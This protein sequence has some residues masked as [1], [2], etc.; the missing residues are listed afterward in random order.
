MHAAARAAQG[1]HR[2]RYVTNSGRSSPA[3]TNFNATPLL[4]YRCPVGS[5]PSLNTCP[6]CP[7]QRT[8]WYSV[9]GR[10]SLKSFFV[11]TRPSI[12]AKKLGQPV[13]LSNFEVDANNG[14]WQAA[15]T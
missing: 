15:Q 5:G 7:P 9:R 14:R 10:I 8:Q 3:G 4:Q 6:W 1:P 13:P 2:A 12:G 11:S